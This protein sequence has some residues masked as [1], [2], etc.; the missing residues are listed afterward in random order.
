MGGL[1]DTSPKCLVRL[2]GRPLLEWQ[3]LALRDA[4]IEHIAI[5]TGW[6]A[7]QL[8]GRGAET[9]H[10]PRWSETNM[11]MSLAAAAEWLGVEPCVVSYSDVFYPAS[12][13]QALI[14]FAGDITITY[15]PEW[16]VQWSRRFADP[17]ADAE[18]FETDAEG[19][20]TD[21]GRRTD[22]VAKIKGQYMGLL[23]FTPPGWARVARLLEGLAPAER[24]RLDM[25]GLLQ[26]LI[27]VG[28]EV[29]GVAVKGPWGEV[30]S[31]S[32]LAV[33]EE[34]FRRGR[35]QIGHR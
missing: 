2:G 26:R 14:A 21:I 15:D 16:L 25:T 1:T 20:V 4:G 22:S 18:S 19:R 28:T 9:F 7:E 24:D 32:D 11:V 34:D 5:V 27:A 23:K 6:Q 8:A 13:V 29:R 30:D 17:L 31:V 10:N 3:M 12:A 35:I 33:Y